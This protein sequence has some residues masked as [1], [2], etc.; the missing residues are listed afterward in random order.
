ME[1]F[2]YFAAADESKVEEAIEE[3]LPNH[4][5]GQGNVTNIFNTA[6]AFAGDCSGSVY[7][8]WRRAIC[9]CQR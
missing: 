9:D 6:Y 5:F 2:K 1:E 7:R 4:Y 3:K 8:L